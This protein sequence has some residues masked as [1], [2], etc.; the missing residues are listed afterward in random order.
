MELVIWGLLIGMVGMVWLLIAA[1]LQEREKNAESDER[2]LQQHPARGQDQAPS[3]R[4][5][6]RRARAAAA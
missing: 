5:Q 1:S 3:V 6:E 2:N 4:P